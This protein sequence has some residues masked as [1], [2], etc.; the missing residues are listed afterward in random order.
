[1]YLALN[2]GLERIRDEYQ[3]YRIWTLNELHFP[4]VKQNLTADI[5]H[6]NFHKPVWD[7]IKTAISKSSP[8]SSRDFSDTPFQRVF[9]ISKEKFKQFYFDDDKNIWRF[10]ITIPLDFNSDIYFQRL[11]D[12]KVYLKGAQISEGSAFYCVL[13]H[14]GISRYL[15]SER[16]KSMAFQNKH[17]V[18]FSYVIE[19]GQPNY[20]YPGAIR[21][22][23]DD[24]NN[25]K[26]RIRYSP[27]TTWEIEVTPNYKQNSNSRIY[28]EN[29]DFSKIES[30]ELRYEAFFNSFSLNNKRIKNTD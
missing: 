5:L 26:T 2:E 1:M 21:T 14:R 24:R 8:P 23:F 29:I 27:F 17:S 6:S 18:A 4:P 22:P 30:I 3:A 9:N 13:R 19:N 10:I 12:A 25:W 11:I 7:L 20:N 28:N 15:N 16:Q